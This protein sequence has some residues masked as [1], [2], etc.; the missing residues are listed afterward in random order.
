[1]ELLQEYGLFLAKTLT[2]L[3]ALLIAAVIVAA[4]SSRREE[5]SRDR[6][7]VTRLNDRY[8]AMELALQR[9]L[10]TGKRFRQL[11][12][13]KTKQ[14]RA[15]A[16]QEQQRR[17]FVLNFHGD[18]RASQVENLRQ[19]VSA[20]LTLARPEDEV[21]ARIETGGGVVHGYGLAASQLVRIRERGIPLTICID[22]IAAS[23][24]Y[25]MACVG[26]RILA[27]P[28]AIVGS[29]GVVSQLPN[30]NRLLKRHDIDFELQ[31]A[32][33]Y[34]RTLTVFGENTEPARAK[35]QQDLEE[36]HQLFKD[37]IHRY[38]PQ[39]DLGRVATGEHWFGEPARELGLVDEIKTS[40]D[41]LMELSK[42]AL[43]L[44]LTFRHKEKLG[45]RISLSLQAALERLLHGR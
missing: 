45:K 14:L 28:F 35:H 5:R 26:E 37:F 24:G 25:M 38:R 8:Q 10:I 13:L 17:V 29:I 18:I 43:L 6:L 16:E 21:V 2:V 11:A 39:L 19:E 40:D 4:Q 23:G 34:K 20:L 33:E 3:L 22:K 12:K 30:F 31:T 44:E 1:M 9:K 41:Y 32:G 7:E 42:Q 15:H 27:A 36:A